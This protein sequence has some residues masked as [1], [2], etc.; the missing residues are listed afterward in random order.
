MILSN[1]FAK[2]RPDIMV[3]SHNELPN[4]D[5]CIDLEY[6]LFLVNRESIYCVT[7]N[8]IT[9]FIRPKPISYFSLK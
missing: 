8:A 3:M 1:M 4:K 5:I 2:I 9:T 6:S 7:N